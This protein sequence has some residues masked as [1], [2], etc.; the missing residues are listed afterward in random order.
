MKT[1]RLIAAG[2]LFTAFF[3]L[4]AFA[5]AQQTKVALVNTNAFYA[6]KVG[7]TKIENGYKQLNSEFKT[8]FDQLNVSL[9]RLQTLQGEIETA[10]NSAAKG[11]KIDETATQAKLDEFEKLQIETKRKQEDAKMRYEKREAAIIGPII[12]D[13]GKSIGEYAKQKGFTLVM[14]A[15]KLVENRILLF[16]QETTDIT[17]EF[18]TFYNTGPGGTAAKRP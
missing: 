15:S 17:N 12:Q 7:I 3:T 11:I 2:F 4:S 6:E 16:N 9:K 10:R 1:F 13:V 14:D 5:Q 18:I 8:E